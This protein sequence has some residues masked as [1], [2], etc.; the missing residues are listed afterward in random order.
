M[1]RL[2]SAVVLVSWDWVIKPLWWQRWKSQPSW[3]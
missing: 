2:A 1:K 3:G